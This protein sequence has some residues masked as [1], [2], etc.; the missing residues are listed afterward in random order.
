[1]LAS[2]E[3]PIADE[4]FGLRLHP[5]GSAQMSRPALLLRSAVR[6]MAQP[7]VGI[8]LA[9]TVLLTL[10]ALVIVA[11]VRLG[12]IVPPTAPTFLETCVNGSVSAAAATSGMW[13][14]N[15]GRLAQELI[16]NISAASA[17]KGAV[18]MSG[19]Q[20]VSRNGDQSFDFRQE[21]NFLWMS[22]VNLP[23][24]TLVLQLQDSQTTLFVPAP[25]SHDGVWLGPIP[26][27][28]ELQT[29]Y[30]MD[31][32][33]YLENLTAFLTNINSAGVNTL[34]GLNNKG[35]FASLPHSQRTRFTLNTT[36]LPW[37]LA[38]IRVVKSAQELQLMRWVAN[39]SSQAHLATMRAAAAAP[40]GLWEFQL[41]AVFLSELLMCGLRSVSYAPIVGSGPNAAFLH[42]DDNQDY[43]E[44]GSLVLVDAGGE[45][46]GYATDIT[47]TFPANGLF[48]PNQA[49][50]YNIVLATQ[51]AAIAAVRPGMPWRNVSDVAS[52]TLLQGLLQAGFVTSNITYLRS[53]LMDRVFMPH[54]LGHSVGVDVH[55][56]TPAEQ[57]MAVG[58]VWTVEPGCYFNPTSL[59][60]AFANPQLAPYLVA[61]KI[62]PFRNIGGVRIEDTIIVTETGAQLLSSVPRTVADIQAWMKQR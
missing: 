41:S 57:I 38:R 5:G 1:M 36:V 19:A 50:L 8:C 24:C 28:L 4:T 31:A 47:R 16:Q 43:V 42:Y 2:D 15:R 27:L 3:D 33:L 58:N 51:G 61:S 7:G 17:A 55:D 46:L 26:T 29:L 10:V 44:P 14:A 23:N 54:G 9:V 49:I 52:N 6:T 37:S 35:G 60:E 25:T 34:Y 12:S 22:G 40:A 32:V 13:R 30:D 21:S 53:V 62:A 39:V 59:A 48:T 20:L 11:V 56:L 18:F 45:Y